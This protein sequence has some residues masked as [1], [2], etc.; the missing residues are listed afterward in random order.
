MQIGMVA[1]VLLGCKTENPEPFPH[2]VPLDVPATYSFDNVSY[3]GQTDRLNQ[4]EEMTTYLKTANDS[5]VELDVDVLRSMF[6]NTDGNGGGYYS[7]SSTKNL[8][9]KCFF[10]DL[11][12]FDQYFYEVTIASLNS[13]LASNGVS[14]VMYSEDGS[15]S[16]LFNSNGRELTQ[17]IEKGLMGAVFY[18]QAMDVY[19]SDDKMLVDNI[20]VEEGKGTEMEHHWDEAYGY[21][22]ATNDFPEDMESIRFW[23][24]YS[25]VVDP[26]LN[27]N[28]LLGGALRKG[29]K[30]ISEARYR[31]RDEAREEVREAWELVCVG[32]AI[33]Y[34]N[35]SIANSGDDLIRNHE[36][37]EAVAFIKN[38]RYN[39]DRNITQ[40]QI[41][42]ITDLIG[43]NYYEVTVPNMIA[44]RDRLAEIYELEDVKT[45]L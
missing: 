24:K 25:N 17:F 36:L 9:D 37:S 1:L 14:G 8:K 10:V 23:A 22:G 2:D 41:Y 11:V 20:E 16:Y 6:E 33:H 35:G 18:Y 12:Q 5:G 40:D 31:E 43:W 4:L 42:E 30:A 34:L 39:P 3:S 29:R 32:T 19:L 28:E 13:G 15:K 7:F 44:A 26:V 45:V 27:T 21:F 38:L